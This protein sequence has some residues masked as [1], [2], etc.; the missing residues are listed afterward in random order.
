[1]TSSSCQH[2]KLWQHRQAGFSSGVERRVWDA[3]VA[4]S[5]PATQTNLIMALESLA[6]AQQ[7]IYEASQ[8]SHCKFL[9]PLPVH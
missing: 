3:Q 1:M 4:G 7:P 2:I 9:A 6:E 8:L 5:I